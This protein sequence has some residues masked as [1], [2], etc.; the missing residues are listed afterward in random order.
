VSVSVL[1]SY[2]PELDELLL[3]LET[4]W[5]WL[6]SLWLCSLMRRI[7]PYSGDLRQAMPLT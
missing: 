5:L 1:C 4:L 6:C 3:W 7:V 2:P